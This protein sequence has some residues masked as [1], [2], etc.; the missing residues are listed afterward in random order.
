MSV[1]FELNAQVRR[2][3]GK[4]ASRRL[5][6][7]EKV[8]AVLYGGEAAPVALTLVHKD[9]MKALENEAFYSHVLTINVDGKAEKAVLKDVQRHPY[10]PRVSHMDFQRVSEKAK[11]R[12]HVPLHFM[13][14][15]V[16]PGVKQSGGI[17]NHL[18]NN[19]EVSCLPK[20][21]PEFIEVDISQL[22]AGESVHLSELRLPAGVEL[23][24]LAHGP[25]HDLPVVSIVLPRGAVESA[26]GEEGGAEGEGE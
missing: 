22:N 13:G 24:E 11:I 23:P 18:M 6:R 10:K 20:D 17:V 26:A 21:L 12:V 19:V 9:V 3:L 7:E 1:A 15:D 4:G 25:E 8:P 2:D 5:R 14:G 16:A